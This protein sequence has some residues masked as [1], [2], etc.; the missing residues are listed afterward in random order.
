MNEISEISSCPVTQGLNKRGMSPWV[1]SCQKK[2]RKDCKA[3]EKTL[4]TECW[5][6][7]GRDGGEGQAKGIDDGPLSLYGCL[8]VLD[9]F[10]HTLSHLD[11][12]HGSM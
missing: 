8:S 10:R 9:S 11:D 4:I 2:E 6:V 1:C 7:I 12:E 5:W 3:I